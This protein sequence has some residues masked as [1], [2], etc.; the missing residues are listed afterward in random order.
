MTG[1][2]WRLRRAGSGAALIGQAPGGARDLAASGAA[3]QGAEPWIGAGSGSDSRR[4]PQLF[5]K[6]DLLVSH[7]PRALAASTVGSHVPL[8]LAWRSTA[9]PGD[10]VRIY[11]HWTV[12]DGS[13]STM[14]RTRAWY[15]PVLMRRSWPSGCARD[16]GPL[17]PSRLTDGGVL[18]P[19]AP[20]EIPRRWTAGG[21]RHALDFQ[22]TA[23]SWKTESCM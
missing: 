2:A 11:Q 16:A 10:F 23:R 6:D 18:Q 21:E 9:K 1:K 12:I 4:H 8:A 7:D 3:A 17:P 22:G 20:P 14:F 13:T 19:D 5:P 15:P